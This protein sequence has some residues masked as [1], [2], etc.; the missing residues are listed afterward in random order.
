[1]PTSRALSAEA[2]E[3]LLFGVPLHWMQDWSTPFS[4]VVK[5]ARGATFTDVDGH[6]Y[7]DFCLGDTG[8]MF[9][10]APEPVA[11]ALAEQASAATRRCCRARCRVGIARARAALPAADLAV[12]AERERREPLRAALGARG[13]RPQHDRRVQRLL[14]RHGRR[15]VRRSRRRPP[16]A[17]RQPAR[18]VL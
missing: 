3:H 10:H 8:A 1:M 12:R 14:S 7:A 16:G 2:S 9:G 5:E 13:H 4:L 15:R 18:A 6:R 17:A 11:R